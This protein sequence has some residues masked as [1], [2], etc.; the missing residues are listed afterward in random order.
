MARFPSTSEVI[1]CAITMDGVWWRVGKVRRGRAPRL[2]QWNATICMGGFRASRSSLLRV[3]GGVKS[4][5]PNRASDPNRPFCNPAPRVSGP[6][7]ADNRL[8]A[9]AL[10]LHS[11]PCPGRSPDTPSDNG[12]RSKMGAKKREDGGL[13]S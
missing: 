8:E 3:P 5:F 2:R 11:L 1:S 7:A 6:R 4:R 12:E 13:A 9:G 10:S